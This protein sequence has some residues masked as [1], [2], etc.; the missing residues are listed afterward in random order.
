MRTGIPVVVPSAGPQP[1]YTSQGHVN[2][3]ATEFMWLVHRGGYSRCQLMASGD[4]TELPEG[5]C[6]VKLEQG[7]DV[8]VLEVDENDLDKVSDSLPS[9]F[10]LPPLSTPLSPSLPLLSPPLREKVKG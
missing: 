9:S 8:H 7:A 1:I 10:P 6:K 3:D 5:R 4:V 2:G